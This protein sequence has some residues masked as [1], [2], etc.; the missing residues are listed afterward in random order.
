MHDSGYQLY[1]VHKVGLLSSLRHNANKVRIL[2][3]IH[4]A[5]IVEFFRYNIGRV[6]K[7]AIPVFVRDRE[8]PRFG[9]RMF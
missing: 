7:G 5:A 9:R 4:D 3:N 8:H 2:G 1:G 6:F